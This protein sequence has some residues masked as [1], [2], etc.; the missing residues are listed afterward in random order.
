MKAYEEKEKKHNALIDA[1]GYSLTRILLDNAL[2]S[3]YNYTLANILCRV[4][5]FIKGHRHEEELMKRMEEELQDA[6]GLCSSGHAYR[7]LNVLSGF[8]EV[9]IGISIE[10]DFKS[11]V[12]KYMNEYLMNHP[13]EEFADRVLL[14]MTT[15]STS[16]MDRGEY[17][18]FVYEALTAITPK[19]HEEF[20][21]DMDAVDFSI[22][23]RK[24][25]LQYDDPTVKHEL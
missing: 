15:K 18:R 6:R 13:D 21:D 20:K 17:R 5:C 11:K 14:E 22:Y 16:H 7:I 8:C 12:Y 10:D 4:W 2:Y 25:M 3:K 24:A 19:L 9:S 23:M 1:V